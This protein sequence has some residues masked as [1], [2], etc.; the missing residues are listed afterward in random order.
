MRTDSCQ[1][2]C[3]PRQI[4]R[5]GCG[6]FSTQALLLRVPLT[7]KLCMAPPLLIWG[8]PN[9][10]QLVS[11]GVS[12]LKHRRGGSSGQRRWRRPNE[13]Q[14]AAALNFYNKNSSPFKKKKDRGLW[15]LCSS[16]AETF[17]YCQTANFSCT[18]GRWCS[19]SSLHWTLFPLRR[20][21]NKFFRRC[22][23]ADCLLT[24]RFLTTA[25]NLLQIHLSSCP[26]LSSEP[27]IFTLCCPPQVGIYAWSH[28]EIWHSCIRRNMGMLEAS[29]NQFFI[30]KKRWVVSSWRNIINVKDQ[31]QYLHLSLFLT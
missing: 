14:A 23:K 17:S 24:F 27:L 5:P 8:S 16:A 15:R 31:Y 2:G 10:R 25:I 7:G 22:V 30:G 21:S 29:Y 26:P 3:S 12:L 18:R 4:C 11:W 9:G 28:G 20:F 1:P 6:I 13:T 19:P